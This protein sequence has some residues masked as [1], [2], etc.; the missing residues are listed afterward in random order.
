M[1]DLTSQMD[2]ALAQP[3]TYLC[4]IW[5]LNLANGQ[6]FRFTD[7][8]RDVIYGG[9]TYKCDPGIRVSSVVVSREQSDNA[10]LEIAT[11]S[12]FIS[13]NRLR[14]GALDGAGFE[15]WITD[16][17]NP[18]TYGLIELFAGQT[19]EVS[20]HDKGKAQI[21][22]NSA[23]TNGPT[24]IGEYYSRFCRAKLGD[25]RCKFNLPAT[26]V[27]FTVDSVVE[28]GYGFTASELTALYDD[29]LK[30]GQVV[31]AT[32]ENATLGDELASNTQ[33]SG[34]AVLATTPRNPIAT[35][36]TGTVFPGCDKTVEMCGVKYNNLVNFRAEP[37][38]PPSTVPVF[39]GKIDVTEVS[40]NYENTSTLASA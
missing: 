36:D 10:E 32:G 27:A 3:L 5:R 29:Y 11:S 9:E 14:Q 24:N 34:K 8:N 23:V 38:V 2:A 22:L 25:A 37:Y 28:D 39:V 12:E 15:L 33:S 31:W 35:G 4:R 17:R 21:G 19:S 26:G 18:D 1:Q 7:L 30:F 40:S 16:W 20:F 6:V 13:R